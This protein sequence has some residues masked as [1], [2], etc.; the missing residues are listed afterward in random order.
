[1]GFIYGGPRPAGGWSHE[2][3]ILKRCMPN[4]RL[5]RASP[6]VCRKGGCGHG[7]GHALDLYMGMYINK[8]KIVLKDNYELKFHRS[9]PRDPL[10]SAR[11]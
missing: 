5:Q 11:H 9:W 3:T 7:H 4:L 1:M 6:V 8:K 10:V 2:K